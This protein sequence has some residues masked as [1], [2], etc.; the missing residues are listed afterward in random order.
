MKQ[1]TE[2]VLKSKVK[3]QRK[4]VHQR[5]PHKRYNVSNFDKKNQN[6]F[7]DISLGIRQMHQKEM[8]L[9][10]SNVE[11]LVT[12][13]AKQ[14]KSIQRYSNPNNMSKMRHISHGIKERINQT[15]EMNM[16][17]VEKNFNS[18]DVLGFKEGDKMCQKQ[19]NV[20]ITQRLMDEGNERE[21]VFLKNAKVEH[22]AALEEAARV[23]REEEEE[24]ERLCKAEEEHKAALEEAARVQKEAE[25]ERKRLRKAEEEHKAAL[26]EAAR[27]Q[28]EAEEERERLRKADEERKAALE[29]AARVQREAE[30]ERE[31]LQKAEE[32]RLAALE[33]AAR[34][35]REAE[36][37]RERL[38]KAEEER[39]AAVEKAAKQVEEEELERLR[40][41][42]LEEAA[43]TI[44]EL[45]DEKFHQLQEGTNDST[46]H[47]NEEE[48]NT[49]KVVELRE[50][51]IRN[52]LPSK[53]LKKAQ[54]VSLLNTFYHNSRTQDEDCSNIIQQGQLR[55]NET[56]F[57]EMNVNELRFFCE[58]KGFQWKGLN[59]SEMIHLLESNE[60]KSISAT[61]EMIMA[62]SSYSTMKVSELKEECFRR[63]IVTKGMKKADLIDALQ[64][65]DLQDIPQEPT[66]DDLIPNQSFS[67]MN[68]V[69][70]RA[71]CK[72][73]GLSTAGTK[74]SLIERLESYVSSEGT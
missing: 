12:K 64:K 73:R 36:E 27:V 4:S 72:A 48:L 63:N 17:Q 66:S 13:E 33:E 44:P 20:H 51:C 25:E 32:E 67:D 40:Q 19:N 11:V 62:D 54:L 46:K 55:S 41:A 58:E 8:K 69:E 28:K 50:L 10:E 59:K 18:I 14:V 65:H 22:K 37:E 1:H 39:L 15:L 30:E 16:E 6:K 57:A 71:A 38:Q 70:L 49:L 5:Q 9:V 26:E 31:R 47:F 42:A 29:E 45:Q 3:L 24:R 43:R 21:I 2:A 23:Q 7:Q 56:T 52:Q 53:G 61:V 34:V 60:N 74:A 68:V 35:Q